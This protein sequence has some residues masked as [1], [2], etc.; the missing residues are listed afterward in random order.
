MKILSTIKD[1]RKFLLLW[2]SQTVSALGTAMTEYALVIWVYGKEG[3]A[4][5]VTLLT[6]CIFLPTIL[7]RFVGGAL[8][9]RWDKKRIMLAADLFAACGT[10]AVL[11]LYSFDALEVWIL[12]L[13]DVLLSFMNAVQEPASFVATSLLVPKEHYA[14]ASGLQS[15]SGAAIG[16]LA[17]ALGALL[18]S[19]GGLSAVLIC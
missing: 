3:T 8:A 2:G 5:S 19:F 13:I 4:S 15:F 7:F 11:A 9:D 18:L 1:L 6:I 16:I 17:P 14:R 12:Y 10:A